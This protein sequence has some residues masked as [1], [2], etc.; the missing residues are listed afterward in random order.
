MS[1]SDSFIDEVTEEVRRDKLF[2]AFRKYGWLAVLL[3]AVIVGGTIWVEMG[4]QGHSASSQAF[5]DEIIAALDSETPEARQAALTAITETGERAAV[6]RLLEASDP[7]TDPAAALSALQAIEAD[8][9][10]PQHWRDLAI[11]RRIGLSGDLPLAE[12]RAAI[13][14][15]AQPGRMFRP[16]AAEQLAWLLIEQ[17]ETSAAIEALRRLQN[18]QEAPAGLRARSGQLIVA[19]GG[20]AQAG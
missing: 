17:G 7:E 15:L 14:P 4:K 20:E 2:A 10:L 12:R 1:N 8:A 19:L 3:V 5:G 9:S 6:V 13:E 18:D 11:L 16:L